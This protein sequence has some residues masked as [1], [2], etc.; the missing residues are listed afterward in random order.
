MKNLVDVYDNWF[1]IFNPKSLMADFFF[2]ISFLSKKLLKKNL[3]KIS[4]CCNKRRTR[5]NFL[6]YT[7]VVW[8]YHFSILL[9]ELTKLESWDVIVL[10]FQF[11]SW[12]L[13]SALVLSVLALVPL[14]LFSAVFLVFFHFLVQQSTSFPTNYTFC[15]YFAGSVGSELASWFSL[16]LSLAW[17]LHR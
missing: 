15:Q 5:S 16:S 17:L 13:K 3:K 7:A 6:C 10:I 14:G 11:G 9:I 2:L 12:Y 8:F 1:G 4:N